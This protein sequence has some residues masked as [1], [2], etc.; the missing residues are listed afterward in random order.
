VATAAAATATAPAARERG[1]RLGCTAIARAVCRSEDRQLNAG[2][3]AGALGAG[4]FLL[5]VDD[6]ALEVRIAFVAD[7]FVDW[8]GL[9]IPRRHTWFV[10]CGWS[11]GCLR[12]ELQRTKTRRL[13]AD[14]KVRYPGLKSGAFV[15]VRASK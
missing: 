8:H 11:H 7:V 9:I 2:F 3:L 14:L 10:S 15:D 6:D 5:F 12:P 1:G 4:D 13:S